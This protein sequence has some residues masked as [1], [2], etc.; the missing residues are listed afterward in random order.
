M[1]NRL[2]SLIFRCFEVRRFGMDRKYYFTVGAPTSQERNF[3]IFWNESNLSVE[4]INKGVYEPTKGDKYP[5]HPLNEL[6][7]YLESHRWTAVYRSMIDYEDDS[8]LNKFIE[9]ENIH[10]LENED[11]IKEFFAE[12]EKTH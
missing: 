2:G 1:A 12:Y 4:E 3:V 9:S 10:V 5:L 8:E 7:S 11:E 6:K